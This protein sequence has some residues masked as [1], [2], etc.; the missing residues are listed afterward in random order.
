MTF[1]S[2]LIIEYVMIVGVL[3]IIF[4]ASGFIFVIISMRLQLIRLLMAIE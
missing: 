4:I 3:V 2:I 1:I